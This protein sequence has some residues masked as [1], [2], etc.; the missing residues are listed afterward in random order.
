MG[1]VSGIQV[2]KCLFDSLFWYKGA[3]VIVE[4][5]GIWLPDSF[6]GGRCTLNTDGGFP[7]GFN[8]G[9]ENFAI[10]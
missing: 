3:A 2:N 1:F 5:V 10:A 9:R 6:I 7:G 8:G 4:D